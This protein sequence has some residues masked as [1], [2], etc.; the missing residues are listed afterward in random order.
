MSGDSSNE[1]ESRPSK[2]Q[3][4]RDAR[5]LFELGRDLVAVDKKTLQRLPLDA[6][7]RDAVDQARSIKSHI[8]HK[9]QLQHIAGILRG[10]DATPIAEALD[11]IRMEARQLTVRHHRVEAWR[12]R[13]LNEG[14]DALQALLAT[15]TSIESQAIRQLVRNAR[16]EAERDKP[17][18]SA[19]KLFR[20]LRELDNDDPLPPA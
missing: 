15:H 10:I 4:K 19:R 11:A 5:V 1:F 9:R 13:L 20:L 16:R 14:D 3:R 2:S 12:D 7:L 6:S 17:P 18:S 8:A